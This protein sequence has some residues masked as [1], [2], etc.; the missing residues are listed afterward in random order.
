MR[1]RSNSLSNASSFI[2]D[3]SYLDLVATNQEYLGLSAEGKARIA[4][5]RAFSEDPKPLLKYS[6]RAVIGFGSNGVILGGIFDNVTPVAIKIIYK[7]LSLQ[8]SSQVP[9]EIEVLRYLIFTTNYDTNASILEYIDD[10]Q[11]S[12]HF[13]LVTKLF[14]SDWLS[15]SLSPVEKLPQFEIT[16]KHKKT[17]K[18]ISLPFSAGSSDLY[19]WSYARRVHEWKMSQYMRATL[20]IHRIKQIIKQVASSLARL[21]SRGF[22]HGDVKLENVLARKKIQGGGVETCLADFGHTRHVISGITHYGTQEFTPPEF[23]YGTPYLFKYLDGRASDV[24]ALGMM[25]Y[26]LLSKNGK[27]PRVSCMANAGLIVF[28]DL[29]KHGDGFY[30]FDHLD[31]IDENGQTLLDGMCMVEPGR[32]FKIEQVLNHGWISEMV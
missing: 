26:L 16:I 27:S 4:V 19:A 13:Y 14:G 20:P 31:T 9:N 17:A 1:S 2:P 18:K 11:D 25:M 15:N 21:H 3:E 28:E 5:F 24:F 7:S 32:R 30:P 22:Y 12:N 29:A 6:I 8:K 10:W 23:L